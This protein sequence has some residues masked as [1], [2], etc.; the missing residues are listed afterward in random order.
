MDDLPADRRQYD[1]GVLNFAFHEYGL[2]VAN[3]CLVQYPLPD[4]PI[5]HIHTGQFIYPDGPIDWE[6]EFPFNP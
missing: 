5:K 2:I 6:T 1:H 3:K 4:Y